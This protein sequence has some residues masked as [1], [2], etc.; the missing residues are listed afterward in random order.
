MMI[1][2]GATNKPMSGVDSLEHN[3]RELLTE[4]RDQRARVS[5][6]HEALNEEIL[7]LERAL[8]GYGSLRDT[9]VK[10]TTSRG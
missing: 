10:G 6:L 7:R 2:A 9:P 3:A 5:E 1:S 4:K 8:D